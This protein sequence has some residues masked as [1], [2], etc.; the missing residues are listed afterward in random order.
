MPILAA[1]CFSSTYS[2]AGVFT[3]GVLSRPGRSRCATR[4]YGSGGSADASP[5]RGKGEVNS[6]VG[7][8]VSGLTVSRRTA[9]HRA[10]ELPQARQIAVAHQRGAII[11]H[12]GPIIGPIIAGIPS[13]TNPVT[14]AAC[15]RITW[16]RSGS[17]EVSTATTPL[18]V[19]V[20]WRW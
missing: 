2:G 6:V 16:V 20:I 15:A 18:G 13:L 9:G 11:P 3:V 4:G 12:H 10:G 7:A 8:V 1:V 17:V 19:N 5:L 14:S